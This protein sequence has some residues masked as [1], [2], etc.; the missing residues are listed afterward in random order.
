M[1][2]AATHRAKRP[3]AKEILCDAS[4]PVAHGEGRGKSLSVWVRLGRV[5]R[6]HAKEVL[7]GASSL[8]A[9]RGIGKSLRVWVRLGRANRPH[10]KRGTYHASGFWVLTCLYGS[11]MSL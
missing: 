11:I 3:Y 9:H 7:H 10:A 6:L 1:G 8:I 5:K 4:F 2:E